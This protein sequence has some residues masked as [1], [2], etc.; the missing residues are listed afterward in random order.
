MTASHNMDNIGINGI[1]KEEN[2]GTIGK[3]LA[4]RQ[5]SRY[6]QIDSVYA[7]GVRR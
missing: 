4:E 6:N 7:G 1:T 2:S 3:I 5:E